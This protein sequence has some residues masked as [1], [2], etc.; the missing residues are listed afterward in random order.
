MRR[1]SKTFLSLLL[2]LCMLLSLIPAFSISASATEVIEVSDFDDLK[3]RL[4]SDGDVSLKLTAT[5]S[6][7]VNGGYDEHLNELPVDYVIKVGKGKKVIDLN[8]YDLYATN[9]SWDSTITFFRI[10]DGTDL[11][12]NDDNCTGCI[13]LDG[14]IP[15]YDEG[16][17]KMNMGL[18]QKQNRDIFE[19]NGGSLTIN[20]G[21]FL[22]GR[23]KDEV[24]WGTGYAKVL[25]G[26]PLEINGGS[27]IINNGI[28]TGH[29]AQDVSLLGWINGSGSDERINEAIENGTL[30]G[31]W[32]NYYKKNAVIEVNAGSLLVNNATLFAY[33]S[34]DAFHIDD[35][36]YDTDKAHDA[37]VRI[38]SAKMTFDLVYND[39]NALMDLT[40]DS[41]GEF[42]HRSFYGEPGVP[43]RAI[44]R[45]VTKAFFEQQYLTLVEQTNQ[46]VTEDFNKRKDPLTQWEEMRLTSYPTVSISPRYD[47][48]TP[49]YTDGD[50]SEI[51][52]G[53]NYD[54]D[55]NGYL[56]VPLY[57]YWDKSMTYHSNTQKPGYIT[58]IKF[59]VYNGPI[60]EDSATITLTFKGDRK[61]L[62]EQS[63]LPLDVK[64]INTKQFDIYPDSY[65]SN[66]Y[67]VRINDFLPAGLTPGKDLTVYCVESNDYFPPTGKHTEQMP[68]YS[69]YYTKVFDVHITENPVEITYQSG[70]I[71]KTQGTAITFTAKASGNPTD[72]WWE[73]ISPSKGARREATTFNGETSTLS[74]DGSEPITVRPCFKGPYGTVRGDDVSFSIMPSS[75]NTK[76]VTLYS[77]LSSGCFTVDQKVLGT[78]YAFINWQKLVN[79]TQWVTLTNSSKYQVNNYL[80]IYQ[81]EDSDAGT[82]RMIVDYLDGTKWISGY[83]YVNVSYSAPA[84]AIKDVEIYGL[85]D[86]Y[87]G[88][89]PPTVSDLWT[90]DPR[91][92][93]H[94]VTWGGL[95]NGT[96]GTLTANSY[97]KIYLIGGQYGTQAQERYMFWPN[98][99]GDL[100]FTVHGN[101]RDIKSNAYMGVGMPASSVTISYYFDNHTYLKPAE[102]IVSLD[103][104]SFD[105]NTGDEVNIRLN[106]TL[107]CHEKHE[108][109]HSITSMRVDSTTPLPAG[110]SMDSSGH[111]TGT[112]TEPAALKAKTVIVHFE[113]DLYNTLIAKLTF[114][115]MPKKQNF[116]ISIPD[117][118]EEHL[119][120]HTFGDWSADEDGSTHCRTC[121][122]CGSVDRQAH[123]WGSD[124]KILLAATE[125]KKGIAQYT[126]TICGATKNETFSYEPD[127]D[128]MLGD[129]DMDKNVTILDATAIQKLLAKL[130]TGKFSEYSADAD[131]DLTISILDATYIQKWLAK[132]RSND[133]IGQKIS[134]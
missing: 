82:Y 126:C 5:V 13:N 15:S 12:V 128:I 9:N 68:K 71:T 29:G 16:Y 130:D 31:G 66:E 105:M 83:V 44:D 109:K 73:E 8:G 125:T 112:V 40:E 78:G 10:N 64:P 20:G 19:V 21:K 120:T 63:L 123:I 7:Y 34:A 30:K 77:S 56:C 98:D 33:A 101:N 18:A 89:V 60:D 51:A 103:Q 91:Y 32:N 93:I 131:E 111:I 107:I 115:I 117:T 54:P 39:T 47:L 134:G 26:T 132:L 116:S 122:D 87:V 113:G 53:F 106:P 121:T 43:E 36:A 99:S 74:W 23:V 58:R 72:A 38:K 65:N 59:Y 24:Y 14:F 61:T 94:S 25:N 4:E 108:K 57:N 17:R 35:L 62:N 90:N 67:R 28:F 41:D 46:N 70:N 92:S 55:D 127:S 1:T 100:P 27:V 104:S 11:T 79:D 6:T 97:F 118:L 102:D 81:P 95:S 124:C 119:H 85:G 3:A 69:P 110:L 42:Q 129:S 22:S 2:S 49:V 50:H 86:L 76:S 48:K 75:K 45:S 96:T 52:G 88:E 114:N 37:D 84:Y 80:T 133:R